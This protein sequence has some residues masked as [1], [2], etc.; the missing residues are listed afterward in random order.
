MMIPQ[1]NFI[2]LDV[3]VVALLVALL[4]VGILK[5]TKHTLINI[6]LLA[7][8]LAAGFISYTDFIKKPIVE[9]LAKTIDIN[10]QISFTIEMKLGLTLLYVF[11]ASLLLTLATYLLLRLVKAIIVLI[12]KKRGKRSGK[13]G[14]ASRVFGGLIN[15]V[16]HGV[17]VIIALSMLDNPLVGLNKT[18][19]D[20]YVTKYV[21]RADN[22]LFD[23]LEKDGK[24]IENTVII[25]AIKGDLLTEDIKPQTVKD[26][27]NVF[28]AIG[29]SSLIP[30]SLNLDNA[31][32]VVDNFYYILSFEK[33]LLLDSKNKPLPGYEEFMKISNDA[34]TRAVS[35]IEAN[36][37]EGF[38]IAN[39]QNTNSV[40]MSLRDVI[41]TEVAE[42]F[43][44][45]F[46]T[47]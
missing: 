5:G 24:E 40:Y 20:S 36:Y 17:L 33:Q 10:K 35:S 31:Q 42:K 30:S 1:F 12:V 2:V 14:A 37:N 38:K 13:K 6:A 11:I 26:L 32:E 23:A 15:L 29:N 9:F 21:A 18:I 25:I 8:S 27:T 43:S 44:S 7:L 41:G 3:I 4:A 28:E 47:N 45:V 34:I 22:M 16:V 19:D 39:I 46:E